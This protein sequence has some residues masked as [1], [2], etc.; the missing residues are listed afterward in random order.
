MN[1]EIEMN[2]TWHI[3]VVNLSG[4][5]DQDTFQSIQNKTLELIEDGIKHVLLDLSGIECMG[6]SGFK[7]IQKISETIEV[8]PDTPFARAYHLKVLHPQNAGLRVKHKRE[9]NHFEVTANS[10]YGGQYAL[11]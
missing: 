2:E 11:T 9:K 6:R 10:T 4:N 5:I 7:T 8:Y 1:M 3:A